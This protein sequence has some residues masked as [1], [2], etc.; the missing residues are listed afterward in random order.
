MLGYAGMPEGA[1]DEI[2]L[3][4]RISPLDPFNTIYPTF[5]SVVHFAAG[6]Y[7]ETLA[8]TRQSVRE[9]PEFIGAWRMLVIS[10]AHLGRIEEARDALVE[11]KRL[12]PGLS[13][14]WAQEFAPWAREDDL[15]RYV[16]GF[17]IAGLLE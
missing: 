17:R 7:E 13:L 12:Q 16:E 2:D 3:A 1:I 6:R 4:V 8:E 10:L 14:A 11:A 9:R 5:R 15:N